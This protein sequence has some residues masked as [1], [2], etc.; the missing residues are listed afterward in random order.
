MHTSIEMSVHVERFVDY[1]YV[2]DWINTWPSIGIYY[3]SR[4]YSKYILHFGIIIFLYKPRNHN[5]LDDAVHVLQ[6]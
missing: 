4:K 2:C 5:A 6:L 3:I 1:N